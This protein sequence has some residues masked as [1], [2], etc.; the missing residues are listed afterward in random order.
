MLAKKK[1]WGKY[2]FVHGISSSVILLEYCAVVYIGRRAENLPC[3]TIPLPPHNGR[4]EKAKREGI[5]SRCKS[6]TQMRLMTNDCMFIRRRPLRR[7]C[8]AGREGADPT[9][10]YW[11]HLS[12]YC[13][14]CYYYYSTKTGFPI[15]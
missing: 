6:S 14:C 3:Q 5:T 2:F 7:V 9:L 11:L 12:C 4:E 15:F 13:C 10:S 8:V 1:K